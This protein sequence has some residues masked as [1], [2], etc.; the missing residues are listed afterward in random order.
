MTLA[1]Q[2]KV[3]ES[4]KRLISNQLVVQ[5]R[6]QTDLW[7]RTRTWSPGGPQDSGSASRSRIL[8]DGGGSHPRP[9]A[10]GHH[11]VGPAFR[12]SRTSEPSRAQGSGVPQDPARPLSSPPE[13][14]E[15]RHH[16]A[17]SGAAQ[18]VSQGDGP[19]VRIDLVQR[20]PQRLHAVDSLEDGD[21]DGSEPWS[22]EAEEPSSPDWRRPR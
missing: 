12:K 14:V 11:A 2:S 7:T 6:L 18:R 3:T 17:G 20:D 13:L 10:H 5:I 22:P 9:D 21:G 15:Q 16:L 4:G 1:F 19:A 8:K